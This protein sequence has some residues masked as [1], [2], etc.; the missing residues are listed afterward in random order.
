MGV[1][2]MYLAYCIPMSILTESTRQM[3]KESTI[4]SSK[5]EGERAKKRYLRHSR[6]LLSCAHQIH[7]LRTRIAYVQQS[8]EA[9][10]EKRTHCASFS[11]LLSLVAADVSYRQGSRRRLPKCYG[12]T[13]RH[14]SLHFAEC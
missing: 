2:G 8:E 7:R 11:A 4:A 10:A 14:M 13:W 6:C 1:E 5:T 9:L 12:S 3:M